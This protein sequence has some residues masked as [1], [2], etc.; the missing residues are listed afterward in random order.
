MTTMRRLSFWRKILH[1][2]I[3]PA[4]LAVVAMFCVVASAQDY[5]LV[6]LNGRVMDPETQFDGVRNVGIKN[7][8]IVSITEE[9]IT[10]RDRLDATGLVVTPGFIDLEQHGQTPWG[11]KVN[12]R[13]GCTSQMDFEV[14]ALNIAQWYA[15]REGKLQANFGTTVGHEFARMRVHDGLKLEGPDISMPFMFEHRAQAQKDGTNG[16][17]VTPSNLEQ[18]N[19][20]TKT[21]DEG[22]R[23]GAIGIGSL[24]GYA[25]RGITTYEMLEV[26]RAGARWG[27]LCAVHHRFHPSANP[28][29]E[30][31]TG[32][33]ELLVNAM[34]LDAP[35]M[36][37]HNNDFG[38]WE[39]EEKMQYARRKG[40]NVWST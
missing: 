17:S 4:V 18:I 39:I 31:P 23:E 2:P 29:T 9:A 1:T 34:L 7:G 16:W 38:W 35:L 27:R 37:H 6:I 24:L 20:I 8:K 14:G 13:D 32:A 36:I 40:Y 21:L 26:Q 19:Q 33:N 25:Q 3:S 12:L 10:G 11:F 30:G 28:P 22:L 5:D 15:K